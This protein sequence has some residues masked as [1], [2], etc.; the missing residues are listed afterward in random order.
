[1]FVNR[2]EELEILENEYRKNSANLIIIY[3]RRRI[4]KTRLIEE[5]LKNK[6]DFIYYLASD[7]KEELQIKEL[8][9]RIARFLNDDFLLAQE[10]R[11]WKTLFDYIKKVWPKEKKIV[12][13][14]D[15]FSYLIKNNK[16]ITSYIQNLWDSFFSKTRTK[17]ILCGSILK[18]MI[19]N[20]LGYGSPL[21]GRR[22]SDLLIEELKI[23]DIARFLN[24]DFEN[25]LKFW[26]V[27]GGVPKYLEQVDE[28]NFNKFLAKILSKKSFFYREGY[29]LMTEELKDIATYLN[30]LRALA[31]GNTKV[32]EISNFTG[33]EQK[34]L[35]PYLEILQS[36]NFVRKEEP[37]FGKRRMLFYINDNFLDFWFRFIHKNRSEIELEMF[38]T[39]KIKNEINSF[40]GKKFELFCRSCLNLLIDKNF[41]KIGKQWGRIKG[42]PKGENTYEIDI[43]AINEKTKEI[44]ACECKWQSRVNAEK[45]CAELLEK[46]SHVDWHKNERRESLAIFAKSFSKRIES[47]EGRKVYCFDLRD[48]ERVVKKSQT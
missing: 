17:L 8:K 12:F 30:I 11:E 9:E 41:T 7:E 21:Y 45:V 34:K 18:L 31:E 26:S 44:L 36:I 46:L 19:E 3:G 23:C 6:P 40:I 22:T 16:S 47:F 39:G 13:V 42:L 1:M 48:M 43:L 15:E 28:K 4:G 32:N 35:Y 14:I 20:V 24:T 5:F 27:L 38:D 33:I 2:T 10:I 29:Y 25:A 37:I